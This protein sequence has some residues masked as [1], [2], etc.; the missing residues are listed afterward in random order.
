MMARKRAAPLPRRDLS[1][2]N[3][4]AVRDTDSLKPFRADKPLRYKGGGC[5]KKGIKKCKV[6]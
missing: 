1:P 5:V 2:M 6:C 3:E 4:K